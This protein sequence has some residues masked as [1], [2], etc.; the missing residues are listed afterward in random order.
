VALDGLQDDMGFRFF[1]DGE[2]D[3]FVPDVLFGD[4]ADV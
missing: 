1:L 2:E 3:A 4:E